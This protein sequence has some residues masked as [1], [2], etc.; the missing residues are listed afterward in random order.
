PARLCHLDH[1]QPWA[2]GGETNSA[3]ISALC[4]RHH[5][6]KHDAGWQ[7]TGRQDGSRQWTSPTGH[8]YLVP[9][10]DS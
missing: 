9:P 3:N 1:A 4:T 2:D 8:R 5:H 10:P 6:A 7:V